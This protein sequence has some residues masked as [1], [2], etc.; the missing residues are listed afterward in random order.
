MKRRIVHVLLALWLW[1]LTA[2]AQAQF[3][4]SKRARPNAAQRVPEL[5]LM[6]KTD[7]EDRRRRTAAEEL[8]D[9][10]VTR[11]GEIVAVLSDAAQ[12]DQDVSVRLEALKSLARIRPI[13]QTAGQTLENAAQHDENW[14]VRLN[15]KS[16]L[17]KYY[18]SGYSSQTPSLAS[19]SNPTA[20]GPNA[21]API[22]PVAPVAPSDPNPLEPTTSVKLAPIPLVPRVDSANPRLVQPASFPRRMPSGGAANTPPPEEP[23]PTPQR[24]EF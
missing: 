10:D 8:A 9:Y 7:S 6:L 12:N 1:S 5:I 18:L 3:F 4:F 2:P 17:L 20:E 16:S 13:S 19:N 21:N 15:A 11:F 23:M 14:R 22:S 24:P